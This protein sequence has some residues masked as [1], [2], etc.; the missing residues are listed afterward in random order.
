M[1]Y[2]TVK[3]EYK[4]DIG[5]IELSIFEWII[6]CPEKY[7]NSITY[8]NDD[9]TFKIDINKNDYKFKLTRIN[10]DWNL[11]F[12]S[13]DSDD[14]KCLNIQMQIIDMIETINNKYKKNNSN[15]L[16]IDNLKIIMDIIENVVDEY[17]FDEPEEE[18]YEQDEEQTDEDIGK[19]ISNMFVTKNNNNNNNKNN[20]DND[21]NDEESI[22]VS[23]SYE[24]SEMSFFSEDNSNDNESETKTMIS[25]LDNELEIMNNSRKLRLEKLEKLGKLNENNHNLIY[26]IN[27]DNIHEN[28]IDDNNIDD[29]LNDNNDNN[30][31][32]ENNKLIN[33]I[34]DDATTNF[35]KD[36]I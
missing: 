9:I 22:D 4:L 3:Q 12:I 8:N 29:N 20:N 27:N 21:D 7:M 24:I 2:Y 13:E 5:P 15:N 36:V 11:E 23:D 25:N 14:V 26:E 16:V 19:Q 35:V 32:Y 28:N 30:Y 18:E 31:Y 33:D 1:D 6:Q 10:N 17:E 34:L